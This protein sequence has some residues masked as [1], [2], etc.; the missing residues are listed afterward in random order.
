[1]R[2]TP[3]LLADFQRFI[4]QKGVEIEWPPNLQ[5]EEGDPHSHAM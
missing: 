3:D 4:I 1:V 5:L 2:N